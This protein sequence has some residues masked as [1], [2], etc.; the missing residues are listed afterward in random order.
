VRSIFY[1]NPTEF[2]TKDKKVRLE[3]G[4]YFT[5]RHSR[6]LTHFAEIIAR[7]NILA[8]N[9]GRVDSKYLREVKDAEFTFGQKVSVDKEYLRHSIIVL[10]GLAAIASLKIIQNVYKRTAKGRVGRV[11]KTFDTYYNDSVSEQQR[12][13]APAGPSAGSIA[14]ASLHAGGDPMKNAITPD[15]VVAANSETGVPFSAGESDC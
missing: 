9:G 6:N 12:T 7:R 1:G 14:D 13:F 3:L 4:S 8:H 5:D 2:F 15:E 10:R 11:F